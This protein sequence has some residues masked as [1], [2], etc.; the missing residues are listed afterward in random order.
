M[1]ISNPTSSEITGSTIKLQ[2]RKGL[3]LKQSATILKS[4]TRIADIE[5]NLKT[6]RGKSTINLF[7][8]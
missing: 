4:S 3:I 7:L 1:K 8:D 6:N 2:A 5:I